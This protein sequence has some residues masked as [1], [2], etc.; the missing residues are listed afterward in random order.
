MIGE[1]CLGDEVNSSVANREYKTSHTRLRIES[2]VEAL[3]LL[4]K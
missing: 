3:A 4:Y 1:M 2:K